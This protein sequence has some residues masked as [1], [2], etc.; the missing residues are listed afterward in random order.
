M[1]KRTIEVETDVY[2]AIWAD[3]K[4]G[5]DSE[6]EILARKYG[7][8]RNKPLPV[9]ASDRIGWADPRHGVELKEGQQIFRTYKRREYRAIA[10]GGY[11]VRTDN[12]V[13]YNSLNQLSRSIHDNVEN[14][15][16]NWYVALKDGQRQLITGLRK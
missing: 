6:D 8:Q 2:A 9:A 7:V 14:A 4:A 16:N 5:E 11:L 3:R 1:S 13:K 15:W 10:T 12:D